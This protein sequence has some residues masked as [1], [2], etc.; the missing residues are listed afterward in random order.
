MTE[1]IVKINTYND[2]SK[3]RLGV[4]IITDMQTIIAYINND[5]ICCENF[6]MTILGKDI[7]VYLNEDDVLDCN[8]IL[9]DFCS[10]FTNSKLLDVKYN[11]AREWNKHDDE[12]EE[13]TCGFDFLTDNGTF[14]LGFTNQHN[15]YYSHTVVIQSKQVQDTISL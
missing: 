4:E 12:T 1:T 6:G 8:T 14:T 13:N 15:G 10:K 2:N 9:S 11:N 7:N 3:K 5:R